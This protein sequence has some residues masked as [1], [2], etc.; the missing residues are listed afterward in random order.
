MRLRFNSSLLHFRLTSAAVAASNSCKSQSGDHKFESMPPA[1]R[2]E[3]P[4]C[5]PRSA[6]NDD[7]TT[8]IPPLWEKIRA[9]LARCA[10]LIDTLC[11]SNHPHENAESPADVRIENETTLRG[12]AVRQCAGR[13]R[14]D[15]AARRPVPAR[16]LF[17]VGRPR[18][19][20]RAGRDRSITPPAGI[21]ADRGPRRQFHHPPGGEPGRRLQRQRAGRPDLQEGQRGAQ[22]PGLARRGL[23]LE[24]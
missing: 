23:R 15:S 3:G 21:R 13:L 17:P 16:S 18:L 10:N 19:L 22:H 4:D 7:V 12:A 6:C 1:T 9:P 24:S 8:S 20:H 14:G 5:H 11:Q 2:S